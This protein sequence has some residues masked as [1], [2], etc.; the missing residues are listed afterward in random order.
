MNAAAA[1]TK[2]RAI[3]PLFSPDFVITNI[4][5]KQ[6]TSNEEQ[7]QQN[8][9]NNLNRNYE[10]I[11]KK[12]QEINLL[13]P[14]QQARKLKEEFVIKQ[15][16]KSLTMHFQSIE[17]FIRN[18]NKIKLT[19]EEKSKIMKK[20][21]VLKTQIISIQQR[22]TDTYLKELEE[23]VKLFPSL[24]IE[25]QFILKD[26]LQEVKDYINTNLANGQLLQPEALYSQNMNKIEELQ[27]RRFDTYFENIENDDSCDRWINRKTN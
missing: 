20:L 2:R 26:D 1:A 7:T 3:E 8:I 14:N 25:D 13:P 18:E 11:Y 4:K 21:D 9:F 27:G 6:E 19:P 10:I 24:D 17:K 5:F 23:K 15:I 22:E 16:P 12:L